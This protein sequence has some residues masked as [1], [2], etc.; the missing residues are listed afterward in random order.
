MPD[1]FSQTL[2]RFFLLTLLSALP[3]FA[4]AMEPLIGCRIPTNDAVSGLVAGS[5]NTVIALR[6][7]GRPVIAYFDPPPANLLKLLLCD[8]RECTSGTTRLIEANAVASSVD[9]SLVL[10]P[11]GEPVLS[12]YN[13]LS[14]PQGARVYVC[15]DADC[16]S[17]AS[18]PLTSGVGF[19]I[20]TNVSLSP[21]ARPFVTLCDRRNVVDDLV[22]C[23]CGDSTCT[24]AQCRVVHDA[25]PAGLYSDTLWRADDTALIAHVGYSGANVYQCSNADC[26]S[27][28]NHLVVPPTSGGT[29]YSAIAARQDGRPLMVFGAFYGSDPLQPAVAM[30]ADCA[31]SNCTT[32]TP[33][34]LDATQ[35]YLRIV[36]MA[37]R[38]NGRAFIVY[39]EAQGQNSLYFHQ[40][41]DRNC[42]SGRNG[43]VTAGAEYG[44]DLAVR[45]DGVAVVV[46][47]PRNSG[48]IKL[49]F[50]SLPTDLIFFDDFDPR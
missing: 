45:D 37:M 16:S 30:L 38:P 41:L 6:P 22:A 49:A 39:G 27:G 32:A 18:L 7:D 48:K 25:A 12:Y 42:S 11:G 46:Y 36:R 13:K 10:K 2:A 44:H 26:S 24:N 47:R 40:C 23:R 19:G 1:R 34:V 15:S 29:G 33:R 35:R 20:T 4:A 17:G 5:D 50:C 3:G 28:V 9:L 31:D 14:A 43:I 8:D 21:G